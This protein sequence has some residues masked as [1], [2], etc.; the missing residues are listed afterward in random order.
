MNEQNRM[1]AR[2][3]VEVNGADL[4]GI[5]LT[6]MQPQNLSGRLLPP[7]GGKVPPNLVVILGSREAGDTQGG[8][9]AQVG[10]D[11][12][13]TMLQVAP[14]EYDLIIGST[15]A[16]EDNAYIHSIRIGQTDALAEGV[17]VGEAPLTSVEIVLKANGGTAECTVTDENGDAV[18]GAN[19]L[20][21]PDPPRERQAALFGACL[22]NAEGKCKISGITPGNYH[23]YAFP[24]GFDIDRRDPAAWKPFQKFGQAVVFAEGDRTPVNLKVAPME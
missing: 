21:V 12:G 16:A 14:G 6:L 24:G 13:F 2:K 20:L 4:E 19:T 18:P 22:T 5:E 17:R 15:T 23:V 1:S 9:M 11:G 8:G 7:E 3:T 10:A